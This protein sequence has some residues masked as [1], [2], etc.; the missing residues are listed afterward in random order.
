MDK[1]E[2]NKIILSVALTG[3]AI[4]V[5]YGIGA[6]FPFQSE[7]RRR[8]PT[9]AAQAARPVQEQP[10]HEWVILARERGPKKQILASFQHYVAYQGDPNAELIVDQLDGRGRIKRAQLV[11][12]LPTKDGWYEAGEPLGSVEKDWRTIDRIVQTLDEKTRLVVCFEHGSSFTS[13]V[14]CAHV[15]RLGDWSL[16]VNERT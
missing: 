6:T 5:Y 16:F 15:T 3:V 14:R 4:G 11:P 7:S 9:P 10:K 12:M 13:P 8:N 2:R 1:K